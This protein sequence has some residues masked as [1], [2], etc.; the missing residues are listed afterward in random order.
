MFWQ[1]KWSDTLR[2][3]INYKQFKDVISSIIDVNSSV[4]LTKSVIQCKISSSVVENHQGYI[5]EIFEP[6][7]L[8]LFSFFLRSIM[9]RS[10]R[11]SV[12]L[13]KAIIMLCDALFNLVPFVQPKKREKYSWRSV[14]FPKKCGLQPWTSLR[15]SLL[16]VCFHVF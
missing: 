4:A 12:T 15:V 14:T 6:S 8:H 3:L 7:C 2:T 11:S 13:Y 9:K 1:I 5:F 16:L 10:R